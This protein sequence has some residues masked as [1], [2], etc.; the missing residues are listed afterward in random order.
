MSKVLYEWSLTLYL[1][2]AQVTLGQ[3]HP[4]SVWI[5]FWPLDIVGSVYTVFL[6]WSF[7]IHAFLFIRI[8]FIRISRLRFGSIFLAIS[9]NIH[10]GIYLTVREE[11]FHAEMQ[12]KAVFGGGRGRKFEK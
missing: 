6:F 4:V 11:S 7:E 2:S 8:H 10:L 9:R 5:R 12:F 1:L 3:R